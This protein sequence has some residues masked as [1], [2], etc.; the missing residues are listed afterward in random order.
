M[1][2]DVDIAVEDAEAGPDSPCA[3]RLAAHNR[4]VQLFK[5]VGC[6]LRAVE[7]DER[8][9]RGRGHAEDEEEG[10]LGEHGGGGGGWRW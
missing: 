4:V 10:E 2:Y 7:R 3:V 9:R 1:T 6:R 8:D 5:A